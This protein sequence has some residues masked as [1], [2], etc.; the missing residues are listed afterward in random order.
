ME[1]ISNIIKEL[2]DTEK[3]ISSP[4]LKTKVL[5]SRLKNNELLNWVTNEPKGYNNNDN[6]PQYRVHKGTITRTYINRNL[7]YNDQPVPT[8]G[9]NE[10]WLKLI[11]YINLNQ[12]V[13]SLETF[14][15]DNKCEKLEENGK[16]RS[17]VN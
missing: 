10:Y 6:L 4:L 2:L 16:P 7:Q 5:A 15:S 14:L 17:S 9:M 1:L 12:S 13:S 11:H 3:S 8:I